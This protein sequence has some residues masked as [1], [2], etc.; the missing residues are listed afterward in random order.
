MITS[1]VVGLLIAILLASS[2]P[3]L[4]Q[5]TQVQIPSPFS[6]E[7]RPAFDMPL[8]DSSQW[9]T[10]GGAVDLGLNYKIPRSIFYVLGGLE[11]T[12]APIQAAASTS[13]AV[14]RVGG[15]I[16]WP[17]TS[18]VSA[19][20][21]A[22]GG[23]YFATYNDFS[24]NATDPYLA[25]G[26]GLKFALMPTF[27]IEVGAQYKNYLGLYQGISAGVGA[28]DPVTLGVTNWFA[29][30]ARLSRIVV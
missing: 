7:V 14:L 24:A 22:A 6:L 30:I 20:G 19:F 26:I 28:R 15:G 8:G 18:G 12:Y 21:Y 11:Y 2:S 3:V 17:L 27:N 9:F 29:A 23:Y 25:G 1:R 5:N 16:Q 10:Y 4:A 13:L